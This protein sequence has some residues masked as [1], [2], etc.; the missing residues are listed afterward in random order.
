MGRLGRA[1]IG[2]SGWTYRSWRGSFFPAGLPQ[3]QELGYLSGQ[4]GTVEVNGTFYSLTRPSACDRW[5]ASVPDDFVFAIKASRYITHMLK[6]ANY[7]LPLANF[8]SSG[9]LRLGRQLGPIL[10][11]V[12]P[13]LSF[14]PERVVPFLEALPRTIADA[15]KWARRHDERTTGRACLTA[16]D[17][18][19]RPLRHALEARHESWF[20]AP[21]LQLLQEHGIA[22]VSADSAGRHPFTTTRTADFAYVRLHGSQVLYTSQYT[23]Q[24]IGDWAARLHEWQRQGA[25]VYV[26]FDNDAKSFAPFDAVRLAEANAALALVDGGESVPAI[27]VGG[28]RQVLA[29]HPVGWPAPP[30]HEAAR[31]R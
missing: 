12:P 21:A 15:E 4:L 6:L 2:T 26:Y 3:A 9:I 18:R 30:R 14:R 24:E 17:G 7:Q 19:E 13:V 25:D 20:T 28:Q 1:L 8:F 29:R 27:A 5:R 22:L 31:R 23:D 11:Q 10:W 16:P